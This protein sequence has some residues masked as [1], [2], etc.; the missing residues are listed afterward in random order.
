MCKRNV[1][2]TCLVLGLAFCLLGQGTAAQA[3]GGARGVYYSWGE[4][5]SPPEGVFGQVKLIRTDET[6]DFNWGGNEPGPGVPADNF[7]VKWQGVIE[8]PV[9]E[10]FTFYT[11]SDDGVKLWIND[12]LVIDN[13]T[14]HGDTEDASAP[15][16]LEAGALVPFEMW[17][18]EDG[19][20]AVG[21][22][23]WESASTAKAVIPSSALSLPLRSTNPAPVHGTADVSQNPTLNWMAGETAVSHVIYFGETQEAVANATP[24]TADVYRG[25]QAL[26]ATSF[27][28]DSLAWN[29]VYYWRVDESDG[30]NVT[31]G[32]VWSFTTAEFLILDDFE[33]YN[34]DE[35]FRI[36]D[37]YVDGWEDA[38]NGSIVGH[39]E[40][41]FA[42]QEIVYGGNQA[43]VFQYA[44]DDTA[45][46]A[47][48]ERE[49]ATPRDLS[50]NGLK[51]LTLAYVGQPGKVGAVAYDDASG[52]YAVTGTG[53]DLDDYQDQLH[54][55]YQAFSGDGS[56]VVRVDSVEDVDALAKAGIMIRDTLEPGS[57]YAM[58]CVSPSNRVG[59]AYR[60]SRGAKP[61][62]EYTAKNSITVPYWIKLTR[63]GQTLTAEHST[64]GTNW[65]AIAGPDSDL[66]S[67][68]TVTMS[69]PVYVGLLVNANLDDGTPCTAAFSS[70][71]ATGQVPAGPF[72]ESIDIGIVSNGSAPLYVGLEDA[73][74]AR[75]LVYHPDGPEAVYVNRWTEWFIA[76]ED[77]VTAGVDLTQVTK[78]VVGVGDPTMAPAPGTG[79]LYVDDIQ[80]VRRLP[81]VG[82]EI[83]FQ[84]DFEGLPLGPNV[85]EAT[86]GD[87]VWTKTAPEG[88]T[89]DDSGVPGVGDPANDGVTEWAGWSFADLKWWVEA[90]GDQQRSQY[91]LASG[92]V[93]VVDPD[94]WD[95][96]AHADGLLNSFLTTPAINVSGIKP[97]DETL[98]LRFDSSWRR[99]DTQTAV[100]TAQFDD[101]E[102]VE[103][104][105]WESEGADTGY[106]KDDA[107]NETVTVSFARPAGAK[108]LTV[109]FGMVEAGND[110]WWAIDNVQVAGY[111]RER[112]IAL[113][114]NWD[115]VPLGPNVEE[116]GA[117]TVDEAWTD[118]P[119]TGWV[120]DES[121]IP[122]V[123]D[124]EV[125]GV[126]EWAGWA[127]AEKQFWVNSDGQRREEFELASGNVVVADCDEWD[128][129]THPAD[130]DVTVDNYDTWLTTPVIDIAEFELGT[131]QIKFDS[132]WR[133]EYDTNYHQTANITVSYDGGEPIEVL[134]WES[135]ASSPYYKDDN[136]TNETIVVKLDAPADARTM[137][138][139][140]GLFD[141]G[142]DWWWALDNLEFSGI[143]KEKVPVLVEDFEG[144][145]L[146]PNVDEALVGDEVWTKTAPDGWTI[147][148]SGVP[149]AGD[150]ANDGVTEWAGWSFADKAW[151]VETAGDQQ[152]SNFEL[153]QGTVAVVDPDEWDDLARADGLLNSFLATPVLDITQIEAGSLELTFDSSW[154]RE[155]TQT[156]L[157]TVSYDGGEPVTVALWES[158]GNDTG[159]VK[160]DATSETVTVELDNPAGAQTAVVTFG[161]IDAGNDWWWAI[162]NVVVAG[163]PVE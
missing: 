116:G 156:A 30:T 4:G 72:V 6:I 11:V 144:L 10:A 96:Q 25:T 35:G 68:V 40:S 127:I 27:S 73:A 87:E 126:T 17:L 29:T 76:L 103:I 111:P 71:S 62:L 112:V 131:V 97:G 28:P 141:A 52:T 155:D 95:D 24:E 119:P 34:D 13:W 138:V 8:I 162:D 157:I 43:M 160:D 150:P 32:A 23:Y 107:T 122:G 46:I 152:R 147:D 60:F 78:M 33:G 65:T 69:D 7:A 53:G 120:I 133:P 101:G 58:A 3:A 102:P 37:A 151:W 48:A 117:G 57:S 18:Y 114:E 66:P 19:G 51:A 124:P 148:D 139:T 42:E 2:T 125:D 105:R 135:D 47:E 159:Y 50:I 146:G 134:R 20:G 100:V 115:D 45:W 90:A 84:E 14:N 85:D 118:I 88:W 54:Y 153:G 158:E 163:V 86:A 143:P 149:G 61:Y 56:I 16:A 109:T 79:T 12:E 9:S 36:F 81:V 161:M 128:D 31:K 22:L 110:W 74:G 15:I 64:D 41:P 142:N 113:E 129:S 63:Q 83:L 59:L 80:A 70:V 38:A 145:P 104:A 26:E 44:L 106:V 99:E 94:E 130:Y 39:E 89:I 75:G 49:F 55:A 21:Q 123:G 140:F 5:T 91:N 132:S 92:T 121:G 93:A 108:M 1:V 82:A 77:F 67:S 137:V 154:R 98:E 136:S